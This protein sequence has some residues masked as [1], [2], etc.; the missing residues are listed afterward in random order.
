MINHVELYAVLELCRFTYFYI[1]F[2]IFIMLILTHPKR[3]S[4]D[5]GNPTHIREIVWHIERKTPGVR[6]DQ[7][8]IKDRGWCEV[9]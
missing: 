4:A 5:H 9:D 2:E 7:R 3:I 6:S 8:E 1:F